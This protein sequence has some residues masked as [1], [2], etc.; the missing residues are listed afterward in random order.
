MWLRK[1][2]LVLVSLYVSFLILSPGAMANLI[3]INPGAETGNFTGWVREFPSNVTVTTADKHSGTYS[4]L[5][6]GKTYFG[7]NYLMV[8]DST[9]LYDLSFWYRTAVETHKYSLSFFDAGGAYV[10]WIG[11]PG[12]A[13]A[14]NWTKEVYTL[15][16]GGDREFPVNTAKVAFVVYASADGPLYL[17]DANLAVIP[18]PVSLLLLGSGLLLG[19]PFLRRRGRSLG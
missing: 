12:I 18:E 10:G 14:A 4:F 6:D 5:L 19:L 8:V 13:S 1:S 17:D 9:K 11:K 7:P 16:P 2:S 3:I 15:G